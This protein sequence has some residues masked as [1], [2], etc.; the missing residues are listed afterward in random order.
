MSQM[1]QIKSTEHS[2]YTMKHKTNVIVILVCFLLILANPLFGQ[3]GQTDDLAVYKEAKRAI[4]RKEWSIAIGLLK[5][6]E[7]FSSKNR[8]VAEPLYWL[9][10]S[11]N[12]LADRSKSAQEKIDLKKEALDGLDRLVNEYQRSGWTEVAKTL[13]VKIAADL[14]KRGIKRC[15]SYILEGLNSSETELKVVALDA[16]LQTDKENA[17]PVV[18][19]MLRTHD[20][21][22]L[23]DKCIFVLKKYNDER[24]TALL[25]NLQTQSPGT[26]SSLLPV[27]LEKTARY[28]D[29]LK[30]DRFHFSCK[31][32]VEESVKKA[33]KFSNQR[34]DLRDFI[35][36]Y[37]MVWDF[38]KHE[39]EMKNK[40]V[41]KAIWKMEALEDY[42]ARGKNNYLAR[43]LIT[44]KNGRITEKRTLLEANGKKIRA[45]EN[46]P[47]SLYYPYRNSVYPITLFSR[48][49]QKEFHYKFIGTEY[50]MN[51]RAYMVTAARDVKGEKKLATAWIDAADFSIFKIKV[52]PETFGGPRYLLRSSTDNISNIKIN[53]VHY[54]ENLYYGIRFPSKTE[55]TLF[56]ESPDKDD[57]Q[58]DTIINTTITAVFLY[59]DY[60]FSNT[61]AH[62]PVNKGNERKK[63]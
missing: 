47:K 57:A 2:I 28:C 8:Y 63:K 55:L 58:F 35:A 19:E 62:P 36:G 11:R 49:M 61:A 25:G 20:D 30:E 33:I 5:R 10:Y 46:A 50:V 3:A 24:I 27:I 26:G 31:E 12:K 1:P 51:R 29:S 41:G 60:K 52:Y 56:F 40:A 37:K 21:P 38:L 44:V 39:Y 53:D 59:E 9:A 48:E 34:G 13:R 17:L 23:L 15:M 42:S 43:F 7:N 32:Q 14:V 45:G 6:F 54:Y 18:E 16:L 4:Y 22:E